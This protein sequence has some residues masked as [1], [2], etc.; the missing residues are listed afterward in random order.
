M[1][2]WIIFSSNPF[3][4]THTPYTHEYCVPIQVEWNSNL[5]PLSILYLLRNRRRVKS[6]F[7]KFENATEHISKRIENDF[8]VKEPAK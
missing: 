2:M 5:G 8:V 6:F 1:F 4:C 3:K 7:S